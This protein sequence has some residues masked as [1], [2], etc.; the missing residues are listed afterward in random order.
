M[1]SYSVCLCLHITPK[2]LSLTDRLA[3]GGG[4]PKFL[5]S[6]GQWTCKATSPCCR[7]PHPLKMF[8]PWCFHHDSAKGG[9]AP[10][11]LKCICKCKWTT[12][13]SRTPNG[14]FQYGNL[15]PTKWW[16]CLHIIWAGWTVLENKYCHF[17]NIHLEV[18]G[19]LGDL[20][21]HPLP[22]NLTSFFC[23][24][25][26]GIQQPKASSWTHI[27]V[28]LQSP[29]QESHHHCYCFITVFFFLLIII[30]PQ[31]LMLPVLNGPE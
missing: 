15:Y 16:L 30:Q 23:Y 13:M 24:T 21:D 25:A 5:G 27:F 19:M 8:G 3:E 28:L 20:A 26:T 6:R 31:C 9:R 22:P 12:C 4:L 1:R 7:W 10:M 29:V 14:M 2:G 11:W 18:R 17:V